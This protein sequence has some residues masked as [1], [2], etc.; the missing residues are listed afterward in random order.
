MDYEGVLVFDDT[1]LCVGSQDDCPPDNYPDYY[2]IKISNEIRS[3][4]LQLRNGVVRAYDGLMF[5]TR[6]A[7]F[8]YR[9]GVIL[10]ITAPITPASGDSSNIGFLQ[11]PD[12]ALNIGILHRTKGAS[13]STQIA[14]LRSLLLDHDDSPRGKRFRA[15]Y[16]G[17]FPLVVDCKNA[18][19]IASLLAFKAEI[20]AQSNV[21]MK[22]TIMGGAEAHLLA[23]ELATADVG[24]IV[25]PVRSFPFSWEGRH[26]LPGPPLT[27]D[28]VLTTL[29]K[30]NVTVGIGHRNINEP[31]LLT[32]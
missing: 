22:L 32:A 25:S 8:V 18:D 23:P 9:A 5:G 29:I 6:D 17:A 13:V 27:K 21:S 14:M 12:V 10:S 7:L 15:V 20:E 2:R 11:G 26:I 30:S 4:P 1:I 19:V 16:D 24:V 3:Y 28:N 31:L